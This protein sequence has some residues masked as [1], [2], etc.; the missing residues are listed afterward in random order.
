MA[1]AVPLRPPR[2]SAWVPLQHPVF[3]ALWLATVASNVGTWMHDTAATWLMTSLSTSTLLVA[4]MQTATSLPV[5]FLALP[6]GALADIVDRRRLLIITQ[7]WM[8]AAAAVLGLLTVSGAM[9]P[10]LLLFLTFNLGLGLA[11]NTPAWQATT[12]DLV[13]PAE[14]TEAVALNGIATN[15]ARAI[16]PAIGGLLVAALGSGAVFLINATSFL[17]V[18]FVLRGWKKEPRPT[19]MPAER[20]AGAIRAG[21]RYLRHAPAVRAVLIRCATFIM[22]ASALWALL[23]VLARRELGLGAIG[24]GLLLGCLGAGAIVGGALL[25]WLRHR[26]STDRIIAVSTIAYAAATLTLA[27]V[28]MVPV[29]A[30]ALVICGF[31]WMAAMSLFNVSTQ[32]ASPDWARAR[33]LSVYVLAFMGGM[34]VGAAVWGVVATAF[35]LPAALTGATAVLLGGLLLTRRLRLAVWEGL[36]LSPS[37]HWRAP[38]LS[39][40]VDPDAGPVLVTV[41]YRVLPEN[42]AAFVTAMEDVGRVRRRDGGITWGLYHDTGDPDRYIETFVSESWGEHMRQHARATMA[43]RRIEAHARSFH[44]GDAPPVVSHTIHVPMG[45][46]RG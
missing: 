35:G 24:Y 34:A 21:V 13:P 3:R 38:V 28:R 8:L 4:L 7:S 41:E 2:Q 39:G 14:L 16:G 30:V 31:A 1:N 27:W 22:G 42:A 29:L 12:P 32:R 25:G 11:L 37:G 17:A 15:I 19:V 40:T 20:V 44:S 9:T 5:L 36:D 43:D 46:H 45:G 26:F 33:M 10:W 6:A 23:P 18:V